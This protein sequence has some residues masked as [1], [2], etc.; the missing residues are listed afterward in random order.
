MACETAAE[1][2]ATAIL[3]QRPIGGTC[4]ISPQVEVA[5]LHHLLAAIH[6]AIPTSKEVGRHIVEAV[7]IGGDSMYM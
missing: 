2:E 7:S 1:S 3:R 6:Y 5:T 4:A